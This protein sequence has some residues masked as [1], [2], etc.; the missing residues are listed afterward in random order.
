MSMTLVAAVAANGVIGRDNGLPW[1]LPADLRHFKQLTMG[2]AMLMGRRTYDSIGR[3]LPGRRTIVLSRQPGWR[4]DGV[5][6]VSSLAQARELLG[7][8]EIMVVGGGEL[9]RELMPTADVLQITH[10]ATEVAGDTYFP[11]IDPAMWAE[12]ARADHDGFSFV[13]YHRRPEST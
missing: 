9:Y 10:V 8:A 13:T 5:T 4:A 2:K 7:D 3:A 12:V 11:A 6:V 1:Q